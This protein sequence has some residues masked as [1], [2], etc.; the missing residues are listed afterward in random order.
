[1]KIV[2]VDDEKRIRNALTGILKLHCP[3]I[4]MVAEAEDVDS[5]IKVI[6]EHAPDVVLLDI[7]M[8]GGTGFDLLKKMMPI[9][10]KVIFITAFD[11]HALQ[12]FKFSAV[13]YLLKP[14][15]PEELIAALKRTEE[16]LSAENNN[17]KLKT[18]M[19]NLSGLTKET[20]KIILNS[21]DKMHIISVPDVIRCE[22][23]GN[24]T[25]FVLANKRT[26][27]VSKPLKEYDEMLTPLGFFRSHH[28]HLVN[29]S[30]V[31]LLDKR[32]GGLLIMKDGS[33]VPVSVRKQSELVAALNRI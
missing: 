6:N 27:T 31:D 23:D 21:Q 16:Q 10:F 20:K 1:M 14:V 24:Y 13:D 19:S 5:A 9:Q 26:I 15:M 29:L 11:K 32:D 18:F 7:K 30:F 28:S 22:A 25:S 8:P 12:A 2:I 3:N 17:S 4:T 33:E